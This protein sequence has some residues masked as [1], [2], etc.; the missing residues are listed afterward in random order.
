VLRFS[1]GTPPPLKLPP[2]SFGLWATTP[3]EQ[4]LR[5]SITFER[6]GVV[7]K[8]VIQVTA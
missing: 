8:Q 6:G 5:H 7:G 3:A 4:A 2:L 1:H